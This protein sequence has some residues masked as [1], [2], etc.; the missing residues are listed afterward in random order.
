MLI[1]IG[2]REYLLN[3]VLLDSLLDL[4]ETRLICI[5]WSLQNMSLNLPFL[6]RLMTKR[7][8]NWIGLTCLNVHILRHVVKTQLSY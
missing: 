8:R 4:V 3:F 7:H 1:I 6:H 5:K 2:P